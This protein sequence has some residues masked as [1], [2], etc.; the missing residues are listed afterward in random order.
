MYRFQQLVHESSYQ[1]DILKGLSW[2]DNN[3]G[4]EIEKM[5]GI[6]KIYVKI[7]VMA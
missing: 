4:C 1:S 7:K 5:T 6:I 2:Q 3:S